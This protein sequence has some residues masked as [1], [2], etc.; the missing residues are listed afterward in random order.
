MDTGMPPSPN[1]S[2]SSAYVAQSTASAPD[3]NAILSMRAG[4]SGKKTIIQTIRA[5]AVH[6]AGETYAAQSAY[7][8]QA[9]VINNSVDMKSAMLDGVFNFPLLLLNGGRVLPPVIE[10]AGSSFTQKESNEAVTAVTTWH[11]LKTAR[12]VSAAPNWRDYLEMH[13]AAPLKPN[14]VLIPKKGSDTYSQDKESWES[15]VKDG[16]LAGTLQANAGYKIAMHTLVRDYTGMMRFN[17][18]EARGV[19]STPLLSTGQVRIR[20]DGR[21]LSV[22]ETIFRLTDAGHFN[23]DDTKWTPLLAGQSGEK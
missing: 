7:C 12:I 22:G 1:A 13:C 5:T 21:D 10:E 11:I 4:I 18:L 2:G 9:K 14:P 16:W 23:A 17:M 19:V 15:G 20:A 8:A 3:L 6:D